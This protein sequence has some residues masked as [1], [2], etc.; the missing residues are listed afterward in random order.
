MDSKLFRRKIHNRVK[1]KNAVPHY[2]NPLLAQV[3]DARDKR[4][5]HF[6]ADRLFV[7]GEKMQSQVWHMVKSAQVEEAKE[8]VE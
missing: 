6:V 1:D 7:N 3:H 5:L 8:E 2:K 4:K